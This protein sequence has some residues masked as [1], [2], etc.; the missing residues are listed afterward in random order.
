MQ[1]P[2]AHSSAA[3]TRQ[4]SSTS[5]HHP[6]NPKCPDI[7]MKMSHPSCLYRRKRRCLP[8]QRGI[9]PKSAAG[10]VDVVF[11]LFIFSCLGSKTCGLPNKMRRKACVRLS[12]RRSRQIQ[13]RSSSQLTS[14]VRVCMGLGSV[15]GICWCGEARIPKVVC[16]VHCS[17]AGGGFG[18]LA[19]TSHR[20]H[21]PH[22]SSSY[23]SCLS[24]LQEP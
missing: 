22:L 12:F 8:Q 9:R 18:S 2:L 10:S 16:V 20:S 3:W 23:T 4:R 11:R 7:P 6:S 13:I 15:L 21:G 1:K 19:G 14:Y 5:F 17:W 24:F